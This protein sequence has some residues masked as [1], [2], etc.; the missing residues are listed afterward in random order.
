MRIVLSLLLFAAVTVVT[1][2]IVVAGYD[3]ISGAL[4]Y[5]DFQGATAMGV[6]L[7][8]AP[9]IALMAGFAAMIWFLIRR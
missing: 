8:V 6:A 1:W 5:D 2:L 3:T 9:L 7:G 4:A